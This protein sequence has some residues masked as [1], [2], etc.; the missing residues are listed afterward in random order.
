MFKEFKEFVMRGSV[1]DLAVGIIIGAAFTAVVTSFVNDILM[2]PI[3][4]VLGGV[5][6]SNLYISLDG[7]QYESLAVAQAA[8][9]P[10]INYGLFIM[11]IIDFLIVALVLFLIIRQ[12]NKMRAAG[13]DTPAAPSSKECPYCRMEVPAEASR[14]PHCTSTLEAAAG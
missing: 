12:V 1:L 2:P 6:F 14:C 9:A 4:M 3:G 10:T 7:V 11:A 13:V 5:D 8:G